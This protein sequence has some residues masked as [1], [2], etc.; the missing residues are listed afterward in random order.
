MWSVHLRQSLIAKIYNFVS[1]FR[2]CRMEYVFD[3]YARRILSG[4]LIASPSL[5]LCLA[6]VER[7]CKFMWQRRNYFGSSSSCVCLLIL[8]NL[9]LALCCVRDSVVY[10]VEGTEELMHVPLV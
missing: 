10:S 8:T 6:T 9:L 7:I 2:V 3:F 5:A 4:M 1:Q